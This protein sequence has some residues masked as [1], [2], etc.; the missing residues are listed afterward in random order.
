MKGNKW[1][2]GVVGDKQ[3]NKGRTRNVGNIYGEK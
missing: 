2:N 1:R 3:G